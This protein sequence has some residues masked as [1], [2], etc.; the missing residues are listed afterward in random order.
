MAAAVQTSQRGE[1]QQR[2]LFETEHQKVQ[3]LE[4]EQINREKELDRDQPDAAGE[5]GHH[6]PAR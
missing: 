4:A 2:A 5:D 6:R 1:K 3:S